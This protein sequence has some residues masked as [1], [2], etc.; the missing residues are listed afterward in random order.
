MSVSRNQLS[1]LPRQLSCGQVWSGSGAISGVMTLPGLEVWVQSVPIGNAQAGGDV[2]YLSNCPQC[3]VSRI[4][5]ADVSG[6]GD[7][8]VAF[9]DALRHQMV[10]HLSALDQEALMRDLNQV[11]RRALGSFHYATMLAFGWHSRRGLLVTTNAGHPPPMWY[12]AARKQWTWIDT[13]R[14]SEKPAGVPLGLL[15]DIQYL[16]RVIKPG[17]G[18]LIVL[19]SDGASEAVNAA[20][21]ELERDGLISLA[22]ASDVQSAASFGRELAQSLASFRG[23]ASATDDQTVIVL[24]AL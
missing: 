17:Q 21:T 8:V 24:R 22:E 13:D 2:H 5:L 12:R 20:G 3:L 6:H 14:V 7:D 19:Y 11:A 1:A 16:R 4:A 9:A 18:D 23:D 15:E 10:K